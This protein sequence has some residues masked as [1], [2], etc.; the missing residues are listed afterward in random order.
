MQSILDARDSLRS[1]RRQPAVRRRR[2]HAL[3]MLAPLVVALLASMPAVSGAAQGGVN[4]QNDTPH[5]WARGRILVM[6][7]AG[8]SPEALDQILA[9][10]NGKARR[11]GQSELRI[12]ELPANASEKGIANAL[13]K[14][15]NLKFAE[16]DQRV[17]PHFAAND[18][19]LGTQWHLGRIG[20]STAWDGSKGAGVTI[21]ILDTGVNGAHPD[22]AGRMVPGWNFHDNNADTADIDGHGTATA[23]TAAASLHNAAGVASVAGQAMIMPVRISD[24]TGYAYWSTVAQGLTYAADR[25]VRVANISY[26]VAGSASVQSSA[27]YMRGKGGLVI[28]SAGNNGVDENL[29]QTASM[30]PV[31]ATDSSDMQP[32][33]SSY[34]AFVAMSAPG[35]NIY[36][37]NRDGAYGFWNGTSFSSPIVAGV[38]GLMMSAN[39][40]LSGAQVESLLYGSATDLGAAGRDPVYGHGLVDAA[41]SVQAAKAAT[42]ASDVTMPSV[43]LSAPA[44]NITVS[45]QVPVELTATDNVGVERI[46]L[47]INNNTVA[48]DTIAPYG[49]SWD[50]TSVPNG[51]VKLAVVA[52]DEAGNSRSSPTVTLNVSNAVVAA[53]MMTDT[54]PPTVKIASPVAGKVSGTVTVTANASDNAG[55]AGI[56]Q[57]IYVDNVAKASGTGATLS[58]SWNTSKEKAGTHTVKVVASDA[59][60]NQGT[61]SVSV[62]R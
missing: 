55:A 39:P 40:K 18:P 57:T 32:S 58:Y 60:N 41:K 43:T 4:V 42:P 53:A 24:P 44:S 61:A 49:F 51:S 31:S 56:K 13:S 23:G 62:T 25:G 16:V 37:T 48:I 45:G 21:A 50:S 11:V 28:V 8:V 19:Y 9:A 6:P 17:A 46:E 38:V 47:R 59:A 26:G 7:R 3:P 22:L 20:A 29:P 5:G 27:D 14:N 33:W 10:H 12:V 35:A 30:I 54:T 1:Q 52:F 34:G 2:L 15:P 36:T